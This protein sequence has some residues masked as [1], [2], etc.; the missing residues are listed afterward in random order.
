[1]APFP[2]L[3]TSHLD[4]HVRAHVSIAGVWT[5]GVTGRPTKNGSLGARPNRTPVFRGN[6]HH[7]ERLGTNNLEGP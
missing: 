4:M 1:M 6:T 2:G 7:Y 3:R 5:S